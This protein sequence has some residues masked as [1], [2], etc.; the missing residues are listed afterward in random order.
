MFHLSISQE[1]K[2]IL[3]KSIA[4]LVVAGI[5]IVGVAYALA[6]SQ[7]H[8]EENDVEAFEDSACNV[9]VIRVEGEIA[10]LP[11]DSETKVALTDDIVSSIKQAE[12]IDHIK[13]MMFII[14]STG[15][16]P[17]AGEIISNAIKKASKPTV[18]VI[19]E[20]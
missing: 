13:G 18:A 15:G 6:W 1:I 8:A 20:Y 4:T 10:T 12:S 11:D 14:D 9:A 3:A 5:L 16:G 19:R 2:L 17:V 7:T